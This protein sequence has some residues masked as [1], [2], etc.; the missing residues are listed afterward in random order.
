MSL[1]VVVDGCSLHVMS[2]GLIAARSPVLNVDWK[3]VTVMH[4]EGALQGRRSRAPNEADAKVI[5]L[6]SE[7]QPWLVTGACKHMHME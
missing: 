7:S 5:A 6:K 1:Q 2:I 3:A 4:A